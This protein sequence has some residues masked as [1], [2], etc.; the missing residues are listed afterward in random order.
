MKKKLYL[1]LLLLIPSSLAMAVEEHCACVPTSGKD[2]TCTY[3]NPNP[4]LNLNSSSNPSGLSPL[5]THTYGAF[6]DGKDM[7][8]ITD[9]HTLSTNHVS[10]ITCTMNSTIS[11]PNSFWG[12]QCTNWDL[13]KTH[14]VT[15]EDVKCEINPDIAF[16]KRMKAAE[17]QKR[18][19]T[20]KRSQDLVDYKP[21]LSGLKGNL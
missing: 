21:D 2:C 8:P 7:I 4:S 9:Q 15:I 17:K 10:S 13:N 11:S 1:F 16:E 20:L 12:K 3:Q 5:Q 19:E 18:L 6:C 14:S